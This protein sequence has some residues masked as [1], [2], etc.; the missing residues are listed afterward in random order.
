M[1]WLALSLVALV[2]AMVNVGIGWCDACAAACR[3]KA[4]FYQKKSLQVKFADSV[5]EPGAAKKRRPEKIGCR[6]DAARAANADLLRFFGEGCEKTRN[7]V[8]GY[9]TF[10]KLEEKK[11]R[12]FPFVVVEQNRFWKKWELKQK[13]DGAH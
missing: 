9:A 1:Q 6:F 4:K 3:K 12:S 5:V 2:L 10:Q 11:N 13:V 7:E 8:D